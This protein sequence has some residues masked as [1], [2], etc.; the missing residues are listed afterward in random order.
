MASK[1]L[2]TAMST[3]SAILPKP[4]MGSGASGSWGQ[5]GPNIGIPSAGTN[6]S[7]ANANMSSMVSKAPVVAPTVP[8][9]RYT[10][11]VTTP[12]KPTTPAVPTYAYG[13]D[14]II[15]GQ[16]AG[17]AM[18]DTKTGLPLKAS[19]TTPAAP[20]NTGTPT[21][22]TPAPGSV[23]PNGV[24][25]YT[26]PS[27]YESAIM[28]LDREFTPED[29]QAIRDKRYADNQRMIDSVNATY[30]RILLDTKKEGVNTINRNRSIQ[31]RGGLVGS[32]RGSSQK[33]NIIDQNLKAEKAVEDE[34]IAKINEILYELDS[35][36]S[37]EAEARRLEAAGNRDAYIS[38]LK[39]QS[40]S[41]KNK[42]DELAG[43]GVGVD[44]L[45]PEDMADFMKYTGW[46]ENTITKYWNA[47]KDAAA[48]GEGEEIKEVGGV[49]YAVKKGKDGSQTLRPLTSAPLK[50]GQDYVKVGDNI[51]SMEIGPDGRPVLTNMLDGLMGG[52]GEG[53]VYVPGSNASADAWIKQ[54]KSGTAKITNV[55]KNLQNIVVQGLGYSAGDAEAV[56]SFTKDAL[57]IVD[58]LLSPERAAALENVAGPI[59]SRILTLRGSSS[60]VQEDIRR[61][62]ALLTKD[63]L[64]LMKGLGAMSNIEFT[65][66]Q[67]ISDSLAT[68]DDAGNV[69]VRR[70]AEAVRAELERIKKNLNRTNISNGGSQ[71]YSNI[72]DYVIQ[73][74]DEQEN[75]L[76]MIDDLTKMNPGAT[77]AEVEQ[78]ILEM[79]TRQDM[80]SSFKAV[81]ADTNEA[82]R[83]AKAISTVESGGRQVQGASGEFGMF[84]FLPSTWKIVSKQV[85]GKVLPQ[86]KENEQ[87][88][89]LGKIQQLIDKGY[90]AKEIA[91][92]WNTSLG[93]SEKPLVKKGVNS[94]GVAYDSGAYA[95][96]V[97]GVYNKNA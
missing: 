40:S 94:K 71:T 3:S 42:I 6:M 49:L 89:A 13:Q 36:A 70:S 5:P 58:S 35:S 10:A 44:E 15:N 14:V 8:V 30:D 31:S 84:Q 16:S 28:G 75:V 19:T 39:D 29:E 24:Q 92:V 47:K 23:M 60:D 77:D 67:A 80:K 54:I 4:K 95:N 88:V 82:R 59:S 21:T 87:Q 45:A 74:P 25:R 61:L 57:D 20:V 96:K 68:I 12:T 2:I 86:T 79:L 85:A 7:N 50:E 83:I 97:L 90:S 78:A 27:A 46:D 51:F 65:N 52:Q 33:S 69:T 64:S 26:Q 34:R 48:V 22:T 38:F 18:F 37:K 11:P 73:N 66:L 62:K 56:N 93:G 72:E 76:G 81:G 32:E 53:A 9:Q 63:N 17:K 91:L 43:L 1:D 55:P 41:M